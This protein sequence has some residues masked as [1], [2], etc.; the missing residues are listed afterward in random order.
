MDTTIAGPP[1]D[2]LWVVEP[3]VDM[4]D[5]VYH[6]VSITIWRRREAQGKERWMWGVWLTSYERGISLFLDVD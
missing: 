3:T 4:F 2:F 5:D 1:K 6:E